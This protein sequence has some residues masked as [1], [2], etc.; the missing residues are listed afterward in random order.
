VARRENTT[1]IPETVDL[2][3][4][5]HKIHRGEHLEKPY[6]LGG[7]PAPTVA[8]P[9]GTPVN[10][11]DVRYP[12]D[13]RDCQACHREG[14]E[15]LPLHVNVRPVRFDTLQCQEPVDADTNDFCNNRVV[16]ATRH[17]PATTAVCTSC[18]DADATAA[19]ADVN[20]TPSGVES[21]ATCHSP[22]SLFDPAIWHRRDP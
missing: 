16:I 22:G 5:I 6:I 17:L 4:M 13:L 18:H 1:V 20:T 8:D 9:D 19:H 11:G 21:C 14:T 3:V 7:F 12:N 10:F 15:N 2:K